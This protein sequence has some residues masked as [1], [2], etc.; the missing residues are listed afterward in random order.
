M[1][2]T[3]TDRTHR[4]TND[5]PRRDDY[6]RDDRRPAP[7]ASA[8]WREEYRYQ[9]VLTSAHDAPDDRRRAAEPVVLAD[10]GAAVPDAGEHVRD[11]EGD[12]DDVL[13]VLEALPDTRAD[14]YQ[15]PAT[16]NTV[17]QHNPDYP[18]WAPVVRAVYSDDLD[19]VTGWRDLDDL[20]DAVD[21]GALRAYAFP[22][23][24]LTPLSDD[25][26]TA[27]DGGGGE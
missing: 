27:A 24:R 12:P 17:A 6:T 15:I 25:T 19:A 1:P 20:R 8:G 22:A 16:G 21:D 23:P 5:R 18:P 14:F 2:H 9:D 13:V 10:G 26:D 4:R 11:R 3:R 7:T